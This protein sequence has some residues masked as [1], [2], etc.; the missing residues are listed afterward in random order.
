MRKGKTYMLSQWSEITQCFEKMF[1]GLGKL[2]IDEKIISFESI[3]PAVATGISASRS[4]NLLANMPLHNI[5]LKF[6]EIHIDEQYKSIRFKGES[7]DYTYKIPS[8]ILGLR[9]W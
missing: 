2:S 6:N 3:S 9:N 5:D 4:G 8:E 7:I 1:S